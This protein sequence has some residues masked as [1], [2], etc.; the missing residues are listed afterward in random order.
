MRIDSMLT[1]LACAGV[2]ACG[3][4]QFSGGGGG[5]GRWSVSCP[6]V[7]PG[8][9]DRFEEALRFE[10]TYQGA[11]AKPA[12]SSTRRRAR[13]RSSSSS[14]RP[15]ALHTT[16]C[17]S[18]SH[19]FHRHLQA[20]ARSTSPQ[21]VITATGVAF[22]SRFGETDQNDTTGK[23]LEQ[24]AD[25]EHEQQGGQ[26]NLECARIVVEDY[27]ALRESLHEGPARF[28][29]RGRRDGQRQCRPTVCRDHPYDVIVLDL[30]LPRP[31]RDHDPQAAAQG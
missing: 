20:R 8:T 27:V 23:I 4:A 18:E 28:R 10:R 15:G 9:Q 21:G 5:G 13:R 11:S 6:R 2:A 26:R 31:R 17:L 30:M 19:H 12:S 7:S 1:F 3:A 25:A 16:K 29:L 24:H 22:E 14:P